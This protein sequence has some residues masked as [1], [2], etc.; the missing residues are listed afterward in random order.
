[1]TLDELENVE[2][3]SIYNEH[4]RIDFE[5]LTNLTNLNLD[6]IVSIGEKSITVYQ[7]GDLDFKP[8][9]GQGLNKPAVLRLYNCF[10]GENA[11]SMTD[12]EHSLYLASLQK[13]CKDKRVN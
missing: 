1:M 2:I 4:G 12:E 11:K 6:Q 3:F 9:I 13:I 7:N 8:A 5:G 10:P